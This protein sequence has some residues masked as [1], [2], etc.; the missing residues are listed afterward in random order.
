MKWMLSTF[1]I[2]FIIKISAQTIEENYT[3]DFTNNKII[4]T[5]WEVFSRN[6]DLNGYLRIS[7]INNKTYLD[8]KLFTGVVSME[9]GSEFMLKL[10]NDS[11]VKLAANETVISCL[12]CGAIGLLGSQAYGLNVSFELAEEIIALLFQKPVKKAR[13]YFRT[14]YREADIKEKFGDVIQKLLSLVKKTS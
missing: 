10:T 9:K 5:S 12:G 4:R 1:A 2:L 6:P 11:I 7:K 8:L 3:D 13:I 14:G